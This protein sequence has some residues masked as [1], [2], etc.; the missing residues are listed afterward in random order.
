MWSLFG[1]RS[2]AEDFD[3]VATWQREVNEELGVLLERSQIRP[4]PDFGPYPGPVGPR[5]SFFAEWADTSQAFALT[6]GEALAWFAIDDA[7]ALDNLSD[8]ARATLTHFHD[9]VENSLNS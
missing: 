6:E 4:V 2:E 8:F 9:H 1:G 3:P 5:H 7:L